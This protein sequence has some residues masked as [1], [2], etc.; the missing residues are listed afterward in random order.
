MFVDTGKDSTGLF[1]Q[2]RAR[3]ALSLPLPHT[4]CMIYRHQLWF[5][6]C[7]SGAGLG[8]SLI[9]HATTVKPSKSV[10]LCVPKNESCIGISL[11]DLNPTLI[12]LRSDKYNSSTREKQNW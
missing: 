10:F 1:S 12:L 8:P 6:M 11:A 5:S 7:K 4:G 3:T 2:K 9:P